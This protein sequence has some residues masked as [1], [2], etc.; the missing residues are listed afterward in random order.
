MSKLVDGLNKTATTENGALQ[1]QF[2]GNHCL[3][4][5][6]KVGSLRHDLIKAYELFVNAY[7]ENPEV[8][9]RILLW[10]YDCRGGAGERILLRSPAPHAAIH[11]D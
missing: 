1:Y 2:T 10:A 5:F 9:T 11:G 8:A 6:T 3:D 7:I 4:F